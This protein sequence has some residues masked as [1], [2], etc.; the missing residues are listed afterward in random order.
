M[1]S[2]AQRANSVFAF[3][4]TVTFGLLAAIAFVTPFLPSLPTAN[5]DIKNMQ[6]WIYDYGGSSNEFA[7]VYMDIDAAEYESKAHD[8]NQIVLWDSVIRSKEDANITLRQLRNKYNFHDIS[9]SFS[10]LNATYSLH[11]D[12]M[13]HVG[14]LKNGQVKAITEINFP[15]PENEPAK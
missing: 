2:L 4:M 1:Y 12:I 8:I 13:P 10:G 7:F 15:A 3:A 11:W 14:T 6:V 9:P 5:V